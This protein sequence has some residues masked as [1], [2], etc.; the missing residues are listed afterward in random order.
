ML[1]IQASQ[2]I[3]YA[4]R[5]TNNSFSGEKEFTD[6]CHGTNTDTML[7]KRKKIRTITGV[8]VVDY[9]YLNY[10]LPAIINPQDLDESYY[11]DKGI[12]KIVPKTSILVNNVKFFP[13][14]PIKVTGTYGYN[15]DEIPEDVFEALSLI[16][17]AKL[18]SEDA[19]EDGNLSTFSIDGYSESYSDPEG[20]FGNLIKGYMKT[21]NS[22]LSIYGTGIM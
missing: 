12:L 8:F 6:F 7:L 15:E 5:I 2:A 14:K 1:E 9:Y 19:N 20:R 4:E 3:T 11:K 17:S 10:Y 16:L 18:L 22:I 13:R 21:A